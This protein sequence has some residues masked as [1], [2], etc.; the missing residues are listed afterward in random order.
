MAGEGVYEGCRAAAASNCHVARAT[1]PHLPLA[2]HCNTLQN[3]T[4]RCNTLQHTL[5]QGDSVG[6]YVSDVNHMYICIHC[7]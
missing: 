5:P 1:Y 4:I 6:I 7:D 2:V 3:T